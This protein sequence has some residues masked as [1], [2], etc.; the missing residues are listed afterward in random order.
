MNIPKLI[1]ESYQTMTDK[2]FFACH[3]CNGNGILGYTITDG[4]PGGPAIICEH[5]KGTKIDPDK[6]IGE[7]IMLINTELS[8]AVQAHR[9]NRFADKFNFDNVIE[10]LKFNSTDN[11]EKAINI[12]WFETEIKNTFEDEIADVYIRIFTLC[13]YLK[14]TDHN[15]IFSELSDRWSTS[16]LFKDNLADN[17]RQICAEIL[18][19]QPYAIIQGDI[20][21]WLSILREFCEYY[22]IPIEKYIKA[23]MAYNK[24]RP[25][26]HNKK[27]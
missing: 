11:L 5:C 8:E 13:G 10:N 25:Y 3:N 24:T 16:V 15:I 20:N 21:C 9:N 22:N 7:V 4:L 2:G 18:K 23:K 17:L 19:I 6:N 26:K 14:S 12:L 27:Y 1:K